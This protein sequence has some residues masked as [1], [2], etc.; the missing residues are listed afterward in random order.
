LPSAGN[1][2]EK[3]ERLKDARGKGLEGEII[4]LTSKMERRK[5]IR[6]LF[7]R[8]LGIHIV[9]HFWRKLGRSKNPSADDPESS[10]LRSEKPG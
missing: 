5:M 2:A 3:A 10:S 7:S 6:S 1:R 8:K 9:E 4:D